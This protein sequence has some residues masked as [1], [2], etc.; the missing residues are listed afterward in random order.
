MAEPH[1]VGLQKEDIPAIAAAEG[2]ATVHLVSGAWDGHGG[3]IQSP[4]DIHMTWI[5]LMAGARIHA[6][7]ARSRNVFLY[8]VRGTI[9]VGGEE[10]AAYHLIE[11]T[12]D[13]DAV[14][15][16]ATSDAVVLFGHAEPFGEPVVAHGPFVMNTREEIRQAMMDYQA[17]KFGRLRV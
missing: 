11:L 15:I 8:V 3:P 6:P 14:D 16:E 13:A 4:T 10:A 5:E 1:Y 17:G 12:N 2:K 7:V 9:M